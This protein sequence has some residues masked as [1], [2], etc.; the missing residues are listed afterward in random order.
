MCGNPQMNHF[1][2]VEDLIARSVE[3]FR[4][5][6]GEHYS[7]KILPDILLPSAFYH[8]QALHGQRWGYKSA[9]PSRVIAEDDFD[10]WDLDF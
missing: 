9:K 7:D 1:R 5:R 3:N 8:Y 10:E 6:D 4:L 2:I